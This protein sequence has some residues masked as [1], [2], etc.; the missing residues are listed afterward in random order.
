MAS[1]TH[2][3][4]EPRF[5]YV[6]TTNN[7]Y[8]WGTKC[9]FCGK[10]LK[11]FFAGNKCWS[12]VSSKQIKKIPY[13][14]S[15]KPLSCMTPWYIYAVWSCFLSH[16][17]ITTFREN[18]WNSLAIIL[19]NFFVIF[20]DEKHK[21]EGRGGRCCWIESTRRKEQHVILASSSRLFQQ[22]VANE[23]YKVTVCWICFNLLCKDVTCSLWMITLCQFYGCLLVP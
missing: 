18:S 9:F 19:V 7:F 15:Q 5:K 6:A 2:I 20:S 14:G 22:V 10:Y 4:W 17:S 8:I 11:S 23:N 1:T 21:G 16:H 13:H 3:L 12:K